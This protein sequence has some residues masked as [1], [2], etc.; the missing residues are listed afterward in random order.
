MTAAVEALTGT[1]KGIEEALRARK[2]DNA[3]EVLDYVAESLHQVWQ[4]DPGVRPGSQS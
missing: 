1:V 3:D 4:A 2:P